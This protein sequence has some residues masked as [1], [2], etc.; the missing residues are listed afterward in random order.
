MAVR[1]KN[2]FFKLHE[3]GQKFCACHGC[4]AVQ[5]IW[6]D[7][8]YQDYAHQVHAS[9][10]E[11]RSLVQRGNCPAIDREQGTDQ[12]YMALAQETLGLK[13]EMADL[14][15]QLQQQQP[16]QQ[17]GTANIVDKA[18]ASC[19]M[20]PKVSTPS[21]ISAFGSQHTSSFR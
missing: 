14:K 5:Q 15:Q 8:V 13:S 4:R 20:G 18:A 11:I 2:L 17:M 6:A 7:P 1:L 9:T 16:Q 19:V 21:E 3:Y 12:R 10:Q